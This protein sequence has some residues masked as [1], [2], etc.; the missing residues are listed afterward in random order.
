LSRGQLTPLA[1][2]LL[3]ISTKG[4]DLLKQVRTQL[5]ELARP[6]LE[7]LVLEAAGVGVVS[8]HHDISTVH[9]EEI[10]VFT[11]AAAPQ[12]RDAKKKL[13]RRVGI[14]LEVSPWLRKMNKTVSED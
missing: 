10:I 13:P 8:L 2:E 4:C 12:F 3:I 9:G 14:P 6:A 1:D 11:L 5:V 7:A